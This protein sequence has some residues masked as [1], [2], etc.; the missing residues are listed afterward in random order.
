MDQLD[1]LEKSNTSPDLQ[2]PPVR[3]AMPALK[4]TR[5]M[6]AHR[7]LLARQDR[8]EILGLTELKDLKD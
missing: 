7:E 8:K 2:V 1:L 5:E 4:E 6:Q 3:K